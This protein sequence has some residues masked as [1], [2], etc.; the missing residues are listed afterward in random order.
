MTDVEETGDFFE[1]QRKELVAGFMS[2]LHELD[3]ALGL[4]HDPPH[5]FV[6]FDDDDAVKH[7][8]LLDDKAFGPSITVL[9]NLR[10][11]LVAVLQKNGAGE[12][13]E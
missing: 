6:W 4:M 2:Q 5:A 8:V 1:T 7:T 11:R 13:L 12:T 10:K 3:D 9:K